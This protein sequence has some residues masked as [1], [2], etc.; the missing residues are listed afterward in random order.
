MDEGLL[1][2]GLLR[3]SLCRRPRR[4]S[5]HHKRAGVLWTGWKK[6][7]WIRKVDYTPLLEQ[8]RRNGERSLALLDHL[9]VLLCLGDP[10]MLSLLASRVM[11]STR[12]VGAVTT[13]Q[14]ALQLL[15]RHQPGLVLLSDRLIQGDGIQLMRQIRE[16]W[17]AIRLLLLVNREHRH[18]AIR[19]AVDGGCDGLVLQSRVGSGSVVAALEAVSRGAVYIDRPLR[20]G[21]RREGSASGP[22][23]PLTERERQVLQEAASGASNPQIGQTLHLASDTVKTHLASLLR[24]LPAR[25]RTHAVVLGL[26]WGLIDWPEALEPG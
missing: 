16:R 2:E 3:Y 4:R 21:L 9:S 11:E 12:V 15:E 1:D 17:P 6:Y 5:D 26:H 14:E 18:L 13:A 23:Q 24:K 10:A 19:Q 22:L 8:I 25:D 20:A 7:W